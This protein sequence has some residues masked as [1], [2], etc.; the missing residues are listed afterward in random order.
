MEKIVTEGNQYHRRIPRLNIVYNRLSRNSWLGYF[1]RGYFFC[2]LF[3]RALLAAS[4]LI[5]AREETT[6]YTNYTSIY[7]R[8]ITLSD[9]CWQLRS[10]LFRIDLSDLSFPRL[11]QFYLSLGL[12]CWAPLSRVFSHMQ[13]LP[14]DSTKSL[15]FSNLRRL[16]LPKEVV[17]EENLFLLL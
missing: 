6:S 9:S 7:I 17:Q 16:I 1:W 2:R 5:Y 13:G 3:A 15:D 10:S 11:P 14:Y 8:F 4:P 12:Q